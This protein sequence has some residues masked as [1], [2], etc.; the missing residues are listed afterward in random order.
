VSTANLNTSDS[1]LSAMIAKYLQSSGQ[2]QQ[3]SAQW[4]GFG[5]TAP[6]WGSQT[7]GN[8]GGTTDFSNSNYG[9][10]GGGSAGNSSGGGWMST[11]FGGKDSE[12]FQSSGVVAPIAGLLQ[13]GMNAYLGLENLDLAQDTLKFQ[14]DAFS[15][16]F[17]NQ[18]TLTNAQLRDRQM[19]RDSATGGNTVDAYMRQNGV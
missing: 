9:L 2:Q 5:D 14:K 13:G 10:S 1:E 17:E 15:K 4:S 3:P 11:L 12:G 16:Q 18:R 8:S 7:F 6:V 19:A